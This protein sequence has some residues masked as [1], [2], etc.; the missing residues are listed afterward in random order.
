MAPTLAEY[1]A[2]R[3]HEA[4][5]RANAAPLLAKV[6]VQYERG[7]LT[8]ADLADAVLEI[9]ATSTLAVIGT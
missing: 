9:T 3:A 4:A 7:L 8:T 6:F 5:V 2:A 1:E